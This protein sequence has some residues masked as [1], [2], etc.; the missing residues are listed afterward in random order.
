MRIISILILLIS[1][2]SCI[3]S[4]DIP[5]S[6]DARVKWPNCVPK[7]QNQEGCGACYAF[8]ISTAFSMRYCIRNNLPKIINFS[9]QNLLNCLG[10]GC[11]G[12]FPDEVWNYLYY[13]GITT[14]KCLSYKGGTRSCNSK[15]DSKNV[16][17]DKY[18]AAGEFKTKINILIIY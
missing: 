10:F 5:E 1:L 16:K 18:Y 7:I 14:E 12:G 9:A 3:L 2:Y 13:N 17:F 6:F 11:T 15:C 8:S 4:E